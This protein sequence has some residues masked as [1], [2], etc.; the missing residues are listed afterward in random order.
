MRKF[1]KFYIDGSWV[2]PISPAVLDVVNPATEMPIVQISM[3]T[4]ADVDRAVIAARAAFPAFSMTTPEERIRLFQRI[5]DAYEARRDEIAVTISQEMGAPIAFAR[6]AQAAVGVAHLK[7][8]IELL[9]SYQFRFR[10]GSTMIVREAIGVVG[11]ITP[12]N[13]PINQLVCKALPALAAGCTMVVKPSEIA[14]LSSLLFTDVLD[15]AGVPKGVFNLVNGDGPTVGHAISSHPDID[16]VSFTGSTRAGVAV[17]RDAAPTVK[18]VC[19][20]LGGKAANVIFPDVDLTDAV[21]KGV[22]GCFRNSGQ[23]CSAPTRMLVPTNL[24]DKVVAIALETANSL[25]T[26][27]PTAEGTDLGPVVSQAQFD[28]IQ[29]LIKAGID[30]GAELVVGGPGRPAGLVNGY[31][32]RPTV[33]AGVTPDMTIAKE[34]IFGPVLS[35]MT[36]ADEED[37]ISIA[38]GTPY[39]LTAYVQSAD[40][41]RARRVALR[42]RAGTVLI[43][44]AAGDL[45]APFGG[46]KQ[47]GNGREYGQYGLE[48]FLEIK[49][50]VGYGVAL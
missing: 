43:N 9:S 41:D 48:E 19:Q 7:K 36:Y 40:V 46:Y 5:L 21:R 26:G 10:K 39:G 8:T 47:S 25:V 33:F 24:L 14:P 42:L 27:D 4:A 28:K 1:E 23:S 13:W 17:A 16:M 20:E 29:R 50:L 30:E 2:D 3:G 32:I 35:I 15:E 12:W 49:G 18:R 45:D 22:L 38:N 11:L 6:N 37:A 31:Y 44:Y 34:E